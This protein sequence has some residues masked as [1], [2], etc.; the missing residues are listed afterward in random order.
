MATGGLCAVIGLLELAFVVP[1]PHDV[2]SPPELAEL[3]RMNRQGRITKAAILSD[4]DDGGS[5]ASSPTSSEL[6]S[7]AMRISSSSVPVASEP[8][9]PKHHDDYEN[10]SFMSALRVPGVIEYS[11]CLFFS[12]LVAYAFTFWLPFFLSNL[13]Y[14]DNASGN[15]STVYDMGGVAGGII[16]GWAS[17][18]IGKSG[19]VSAA[20]LLMCLPGLWVYS[21]F[22]GYGIALNVSLMFV[23]GILV[24]GPYTLISGVVAAD[25]GN[26]PSLKGNP[27]AMSTVTGQ[28]QCDKQRAKRGARG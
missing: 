22:A 12:K 2:L 6:D 26:H 13:N 16:A 15:L 1:H 25:L 27:K 24:N 7:E 21:F 28:K 23:V 3:D 18:R 17:D 9:A 11:A 19:L 20:M 14:S 5:R 10:I 8:P 4:E